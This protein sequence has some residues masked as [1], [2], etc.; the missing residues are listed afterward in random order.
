MS[1]RAAWVVALGE[2]PLSKEQQEDVAII[3]DVPDRMLALKDGAK[4]DVKEY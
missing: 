2:C 3:F 1:E 4:E